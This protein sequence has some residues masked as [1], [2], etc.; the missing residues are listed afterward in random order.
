[1]S[2]LNRRK[3]ELTPNDYY[4]DEIRRLEIAYRTYLDTHSLPVPS[5]Q[6]IEWLE[7]EIGMFCHFSINTFYN[8]EWS[9]GTLDISKFNPKMLDCEQWVRVAKEL[10]AGYMIVTAKHHDGFCNWPTNTTEYCVRNTPYKNGKGD[11]VREF[12]EACKKYDMKIGIYLSPWDRNQ[13]RFGCYK[14][15]KAYDEYYCKQLTELLT[16]YDTD[17]F[18]IWFDG[19]G[20]EGHTYNWDKIVGV[21]KQ[22]QPQALIFGMGDPT[23][24]WVGNEYG[25][26]PYPSWYVL[27]SPGGFAEMEKIEITGV[28]LYLRDSYGLGN[29]FIPPECDVPI[30]RFHWFYHTNDRLLLKPL[31][32]LIDLYDKSVGRGCNLLLNLAPNRD[33]LIEKSDAKRAK[34]L[35]ALIRERYSTPIKEINGKKGVSSLEIVLD[36]P[37]E[38]NC[39]ISQEELS[40]GQRIREYH[41][42]VWS[43]NQWNI[44]YEGSTIGH[45]KIDHIKS[46]KTSKIRLTV[47]NSLL[48]PTIKHLAVFNIQK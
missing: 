8:K 16:R 30:R 11:V 37:T 39:I 2:K 40:T 45:K 27:N 15:E 17:F 46:V 12:I 26:A 28:G 31:K 43:E 18:E 4:S 42:Q 47:I 33:G 6:Q 19:A 36:S 21:I 29:R 20:S 22:H 10:G 32:L 44:V 25:Y 9:D 34:Q 7:T 1:M 41:L 3:S 24:R 13:E 23:I 38:I 48:P 35:G 5:S 14:D